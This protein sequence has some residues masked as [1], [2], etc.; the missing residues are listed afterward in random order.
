MPTPKAITLNRHILLAHGTD[1]ECEYESEMTIKGT[2]PVQFAPICPKC[3]GAL[4]LYSKIPIK[5]VRGTSP[6]D[7]KRSKTQRPH[8][9]EEA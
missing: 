1:V 6:D 8:P 2:R 3:G 9:S 4:V 7:K 5:V